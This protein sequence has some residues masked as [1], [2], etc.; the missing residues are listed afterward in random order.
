MNKRG[1]FTELLMDYAIYL[2]LIVFFTL[3]LLGVIWQQRNGAAVWEEYYAKEIVKVINLAE[4]GDEI[5][6]DVHKG[7][8]I[9]LR[10]EID[11]SEMF[12]VYNSR[13]EVC[14]KLSKGRRTCYHYFNDVD[15]VDF[16]IK[17]GVPTNVFNFKVVEAQRSGG[18]NG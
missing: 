13:D 10:N 12:V 5:S 2:I 11:F 8:E 6:L 14:V 15:I 18:E 4:P 16:G 7:T 3:L 17:Q 1:T 9:G